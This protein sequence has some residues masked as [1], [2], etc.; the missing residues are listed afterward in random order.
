[1]SFDLI[2]AVTPHFLTNDMTSMSKVF[3]RAET[4]DLPESTVKVWWD[5]LQLA[6]GAE[7]MPVIES[8]FTAV[9]MVPEAMIDPMS[10]L[11]LT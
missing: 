11:L 9:E 8:V 6:D 7:Y 5:I 2:L 3:H 1:M 10:Q 4:T